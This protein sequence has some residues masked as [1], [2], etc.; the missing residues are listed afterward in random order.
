MSMV[1][2]EQYITDDEAKNYILEMCPQIYS[3][4]LEFIKIGRMK[5]IDKKDSLFSIL[6]RY[7]KFQLELSNLEIQFL[8]FEEA[9]K[10]I[11]NA[12][13]H[14]PRHLDNLI[15]PTELEEYESLLRLIP[16]KII[17]AIEDKYF[18]IPISYE[19]DEYNYYQNVWLEKIP[20]EELEFLYNNSIH[21]TFNDII[22][23][24][25][26]FQ[27]LIEFERLR[28]DNRFC[29]YTHTDLYSIYYLARKY[30]Q[31]EKVLNNKTYLK[32]MEDLY[33]V[34]LESFIKP[35]ID[36]LKDAEIISLSTFKNVTKVRFQNLCLL[37][38]L[39]TIR[40]KDLKHNF[41]KRFIKFVRQEFRNGDTLE[42]LYKF[43][44][45]YVNREW[46]FVAEDYLEDCFPFLRN[47]V[48]K[49]DAELY[50]TFFLAKD[51]E[52]IETIIDKTIGYICK[53]EARC[54]KNIL[55]KKFKSYKKWR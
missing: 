43:I 9:N 11:E 31:Y 3:D 29:Y 45:S 36:N 19:R 48:N 2:K 40:Y 1:I 42:Q 18:Y 46:N 20:I 52:Q 53:L 22:P 44:Q 28:C 12:L 15:K 39:L 4:A 21:K 35:V 41:C 30:N 51:I 24:D 33:L 13:F 32:I 26:E 25:M 49:N 47:Y 55:D 54:Y 8:E 10:K 50:S 23:L 5:H 27:D 17:I 34:K 14:F 6:L 16:V 38:H 7:F 37:F